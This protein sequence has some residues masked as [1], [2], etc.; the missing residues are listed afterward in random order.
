MLTWII[1]IALVT[2]FSLQ[3]NALS[4]AYEIPKSGSKAK[5]KK[6]KE[7]II[8]AELA[9]DFR[10]MVEIELFENDAIIYPSE[11]NK[12]RIELAYIAVGLDNDEAQLLEEAMKQNLIKQS[13]NKI[14]LSTR[15]YEHY[16]QFSLGPLWGKIYMHLGSDKKISIDEFKYTKVEIYLPEDMDLKIDAKY[17]SLRQKQS[18]NG[19]VT[20]KGY[21][22]EYSVPSITG[23]LE[24][25]GKYSKFYI[26]EAGDTKLKL[27][28][29]K[30]RSDKLENV[31]ADAKYSGVRVNKM[32][33]LT[34]TA[35]EGSVNISTLTDANINGKYC[36][37][38][39]G[40]CKNINADLYEGHINIDNAK[41]GQLNGKYLES[42]IG[43]IIAL[44][45]TNGYE[46]DLSI[47]QIEK[48]TSRNGK[49]CGYEIGTL[50][51]SVELVS[52][53]ED[54][55]F[56]DRVEKS[57]RS[58]ITNGKYMVIKLGIEKAANYS[59]EGKI[60]YYNFELKQ[61][62]F[63]NIVHKE[64]G[65]KLEYSYQRGSANQNIKMVKLN[66]YEID[67]IIK[68]L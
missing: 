15:F 16:S 32:Q 33:A 61:S 43:K 19:N 26:P 1:S 46:N 21:D 13:G 12:I 39:L 47:K 7:K 38:D 45:M 58:I 4:I 2:G 53:Y 14:K 34:I 31:E 30:F 68:H 9:L 25:D 50:K 35:Y 27:Y 59:L 36:E 67:V 37:I 23:T 63:S 60:Q 3:V 55:L 24:V 52:S 10:P 17:N 51:E 44:E 66:G 64:H 29:C 62:D 6:Q 57:F 8:K 49:Y 11:N 65:S 56:I 18:V 40:D 41:Q 48:L 28:E 22:M 20:I 5:T 54:D 42:R